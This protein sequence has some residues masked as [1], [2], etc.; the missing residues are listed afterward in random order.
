MPKILE[1]ARLLNRDITTI[2]MDL[3]ST[4]PILLQSETNMYESL[5]KEHCT[6][7]LQKYD[8]D[9]ELMLYTDL[10]K[11]SC[12]TIALLTVWFMYS[13]KRLT[14]HP[15]GL[16]ALIF[17]FLSGFLQLKDQQ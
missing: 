3:N 7:M 14:S 17:I 11:F 9:H 1:M 4:Q 10:L 12:L 13:D 16:I 5:V 6:A 2:L 15:G 8:D